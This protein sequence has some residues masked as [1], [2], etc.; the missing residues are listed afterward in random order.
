MSMARRPAAADLRDPDLF[1]LLIDLA[2]SIDQ[3]P[4]P[5][6]DTPLTSGVEPSPSSE[7]GADDLSRRWSTTSE[8]PTSH[9][10][11]RSAPSVPLGWTG[12][13]QT[14]C[15]RSRTCQLR[16]VRTSSP[17]TR[18]APCRPTQV[19]GA[20][21]TWPP[22]PDGAGGVQS[23][24][25]S[26]PRTT[27]PSHGGGSSYKPL[28][29]EWWQSIPS[30]SRP[31]PPI[32]SRGYRKNRSRRGRQDR[33]SE[34]A[35]TSLPQSSAPRVDGEPADALSTV[36]NAASWDQTRDHL[37]RLSTAQEWAAAAR[38]TL[39]AHYTDPRVVSAMW[40]AL[41]RAR[42]RRRRGCSNP[43]RRRELHRRRAPTAPMVGV[44]LDPTTAAIARR[45]HPDATSAHESFADTPRCR[46]GYFDAAIG[47]VPFGDVSACTTRPQPAAATASTTTSSSSRSR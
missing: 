7:T 22:W 46:T 8:N 20:S 12:P 31:A 21:S 30:T 40:A 45:L 18:C 47:N 44:E 29:C 1:S 43:V 28:Q 9:K 15:R 25:R 2:D 11:Q 19:T 35:P 27:R 38:S 3:K 37:R 17:S 16:C 6:A 32:R 34:S 33:P 39:N 36:A 42:L 10:R 13:S 26:T 24:N 41:S 4:A 14:S 23:R 5:T